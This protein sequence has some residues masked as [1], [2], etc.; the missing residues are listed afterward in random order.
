MSNNEAGAIRI[1]IGAP[2]EEIRSRLDAI[3]DENALPERAQ[4]HNV[5]WVSPVNPEIFM[6]GSKMV[7]NAPNLRLQ[8]FPN[9]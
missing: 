2:V 7:Q 5:F 9:K 1:N 3:E 4:V 6:A 8:S